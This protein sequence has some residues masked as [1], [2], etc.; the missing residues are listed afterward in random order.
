LRAEYNV[1]TQ[2]TECIRTWL[3]P[4]IDCQVCGNE[5]L[6]ATSETFM[7]VFKMSWLMSSQVGE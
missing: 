7:F 5:D 4:Q 6:A 3:V 1:K 2:F